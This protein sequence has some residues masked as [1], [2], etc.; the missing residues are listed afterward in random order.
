MD[1]F[2][3][4]NIFETKG[5]EYIIVIAFLLL[6]I[7]F[8]YLINRPIKVKE[9]INSAIGYLN[10]K[11]LRIPRGIFYS[12][13]HTWTYLEP[14]GY[15][16][17]GIDDLLVHLTGPVKI[18]QTLN[19]GDKINVGDKIAEIYQDEKMLEITSTLSGEVAFINEQ[20][21]SQPELLN[22]DPYNK[23]W[24]IKIKPN[25]W[26]EETKEYILA[27]S[28]PKWF[29]NEIE[30]FKD[31]IAFSLKKNNPSSSE[32]VLQ[33]GGELIDF[34]LAGL[35]TDIWNDFQKSYLKQ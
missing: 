20:L 11:I 5:I 31:F 30:R 21:I 34:P 22:R 25:N 13:N 7:V 17:T 18:K 27:D 8:W 2:T 9:S 33:E 24:F 32:V 14:E 26:I 28:A 19:P 16:K 12:K 4:T 29:Q 35:S 23:G 10:D 15:A 1:E 3:Y 6:I